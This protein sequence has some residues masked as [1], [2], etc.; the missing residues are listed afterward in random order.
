[1]RRAGCAALPRT[2]PRAGSPRWQAAASGHPSG[3]NGA[4]D[5]KPSTAA[6]HEEEVVRGDARGA[7]GNGARAVKASRIY[8]FRKKKKVLLPS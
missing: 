2:V 6:A 1:M 5:A 3:H 8:L 7:H 4:H